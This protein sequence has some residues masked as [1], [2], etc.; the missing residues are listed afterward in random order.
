M[1][2]WLSDPYAAKAVQSLVLALAVW[3]LAKIAILVAAKRSKRTSEA[4][5]VIKYAALFLLG[6]ALVFIWLE[7]IGPILTALTIVAAALTI[8]AK[9]LILNF[10]GSFVIFWR[11]LFA[12]GDRVQVGA[13]TGDVIDKGLFYFTLL[14]AG[15]TGL[16]GHST[17]RLVKVPNALVLTL[18]VVN[19]TRG[20]GYVWNEIGL[21]VSAD[22][23]WEAARRL[24]LD[25]VKT[26]YADERVDLERVKQIFEKKRVFFKE[27]G[28]RVYMDVTTGGFLLTLRYLCRSRLI[29]E[30][31]DA[32]VT[33]FVRDMEKAGVRL[34]EMQ[35]GSAPL[36]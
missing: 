10:I 5:F 26:Y 19:A 22:S 35:P 12:I 27:L 14:E 24:L 20:A 18:P 34:A 16:S 30:S 29:R 11:E 32:I 4:P 33:R 17:G 21:A 2:Q 7:G 3:V 1:Q 9:E 8:V 23:D 13:S 15:Q 6:I 25:A 28:P 31:R 36:S